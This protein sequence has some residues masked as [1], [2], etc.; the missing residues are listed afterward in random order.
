MRHWRFESHE[1]IRAGQP[2]FSGASSRSGLTGR[3]PDQRRGGA[4][5]G[6]IEVSI[7]PIG[8]DSNSLSAYVAAPSRCSRERA[9]ASDLRRWETII[10]GDLDEILRVV[11]RNARDVLQGRAVRVLTQIRI[12][13]RRDVAG[14]RSRRCAPFLKN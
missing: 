13:D 7:V 12:D 11:R 5:D 2:K 1:T 10:S 3:A 6:R 4:F 8:I 14:T 9:R